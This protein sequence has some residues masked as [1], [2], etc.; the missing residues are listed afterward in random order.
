VL[1]HCAAGGVGQAAL[2]LCQHL[3]AQA[4]ATCSFEKRPLLAELGMSPDRI[5][6]SRSSSWFDDLMAVTGQQGMHVVLNCLTG[7]HQQLGLQALAPNGR[8]IELG[9]MDVYRYVPWP[10]DNYEA[11]R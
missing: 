2:A 7:S 1:I 11:D 5:F 3:G 8:F 4:Y 6:D 10:R 9:K